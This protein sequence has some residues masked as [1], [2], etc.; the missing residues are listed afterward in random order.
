[1]RES[2]LDTKKGTCYR[3]G[4]HGSTQRHHIMYGV[5]NR[6]LAE[7]DGLWVYLCLDCHNIPPDG[8][9]FNPKNDLWLKR[10]GQ[11]AYEQKLSQNG[12]EDVR[13]AFIK[14]YGKSYL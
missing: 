6:R 12:V 8:V 4:V 10:V 1:M 11:Q 13:G 9:H 7:E 3:C 5:A 14:R 2:L